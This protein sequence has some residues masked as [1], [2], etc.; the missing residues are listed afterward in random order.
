MESLC[1]VEFIHKVFSYFSM[2]VVHLHFVQLE[3]VLDD[4]DFSRGRI[5]A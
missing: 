2:L 3:D 5:E 1:S 4:L